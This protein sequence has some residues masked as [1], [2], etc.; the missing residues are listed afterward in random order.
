M[1]NQYIRQICVCC[2]VMFDLVCYFILDMYKK[3]ATQKV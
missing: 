1:T 3:F 2:G